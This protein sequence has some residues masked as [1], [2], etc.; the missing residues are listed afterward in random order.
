[1]LLMANEAFTLLRLN[2]TLERSPVICTFTVGTCSSFCIPPVCR[3]CRCVYSGNLT[4]HLRYAIITA[5]SRIVS[6]RFLALT[7]PKD[8]QR[9]SAPGTEL[10]K[11][12]LPCSRRSQYSVFTRTIIACDGKC[13]IF[14]MYHRQL[15]IQQARTKFATK[16]FCQC[17]LKPHRK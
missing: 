9:G 12:P 17:C 7:A 14:S 15:Q 4:A 2:I 16:L 5:I 6:P 3:A 10:R 1:M 8:H 13:H 11:M